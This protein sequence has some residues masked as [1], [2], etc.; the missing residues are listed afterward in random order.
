MQHICMYILKICKNYAR[1][2]QEL[3]KRY[4]LNMHKYALNMQKSASNLQYM[5]LK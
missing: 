2:M 1:T 5:H 3:C 4:A